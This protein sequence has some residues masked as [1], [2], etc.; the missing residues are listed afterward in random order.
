MKPFSASFRAAAR[1]A[2]VGGTRSILRFSASSRSIVGT[3]LGARLRNR[4]FL[5]LNL[6]V[7]GGLD[8]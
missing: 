7:E 4:N 2:L 3:A 5:A 1:W 8:S 6:L